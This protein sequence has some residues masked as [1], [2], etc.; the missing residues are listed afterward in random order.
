MAE[1]VYLTLFTVL[2][3]APNTQSARQTPKYCFLVGHVFCI[4][5]NPQYRLTPADYRHS[6]LP[7]SY[8]LHHL[9]LRHLSQVVK[10][11]PCLGFEPG[12]S[13]TRVR[14]SNNY[15]IE[16]FRFIYLLKRFY[17]IYLLLIIFI[18]IVCWA[19]RRNGICILNVTTYLCIFKN[20]NN[21]II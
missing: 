21:I 5:N 15:T 4:H 16:V 18:P 2:S 13:R 9:V 10:N 17:C 7:S 14:R 11:P 20:K 6:K 8:Q 19:I 1:L 12:T 3:E